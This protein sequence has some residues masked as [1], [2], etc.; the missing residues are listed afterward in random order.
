MARSKEMA[1]NEMLRDVRLLFNRMH[2]YVSMA[3]EHLD[4][5]V[6]MR[7]VLEGLVVEGPQTVPK[8]AKNR[9]VSR[10]NIQII[11]NQ[12]LDRGYAETQDNPTHKRSSLVL[13]TTKGL[14]IFN[15]IRQLERPLLE[16][17]SGMLS[18]RELKQTSQTLVRV[19]DFFEDETE[20]L[21]S[22]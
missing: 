10:Q 4:V 20:R 19:L 16:E 8:I 7:A 5:N 1:L 6:S 14:Q 22:N 11:V 9:S 13:I 2:Q 15:E 17:L 21:K 18:E 3:Q 12:L